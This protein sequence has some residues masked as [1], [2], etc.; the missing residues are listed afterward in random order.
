LNKIGGIGIELWTMTEN[1]LFDNIYVGHSVEDAKTFAV[2]TYDV[3]KPLEEAADKVAKVE[4][5]EETEEK[6]FKEDPIGYLRQK[7]LTF[8]ELATIDPVLAFKT[9]PETGIALGGALLTLFGMLGALFGLVGGSQKPVAKSSKKT[10]APSPDDK[11]PVEKAPVAPAG[12]DKKD[13]DEKVKRR[14]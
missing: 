7:A 11:K 4:D 6:T 3:K 2:E 13:E 1:I 5:D 10:D 9:Y 12:G 14:K 8:I